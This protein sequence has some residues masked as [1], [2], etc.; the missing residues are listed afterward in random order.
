MLMIMIFRRK[1]ALISIY[2]CFLFRIDFKFLLQNLFICAR[3][4]NTTVEFLPYYKLY[5][6]FETFLQLLFFEI[7]TLHY[8][9][10]EF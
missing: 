3:G 5:S 9:L 6:N 10:L 4:K 7:H 1:I 2:F 8:S